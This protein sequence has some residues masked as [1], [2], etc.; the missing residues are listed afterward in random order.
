MR[1]GSL[2]VGCLLLATMAAAARPHS[3]PE[4]RA[5]WVTRTALTSPA[6][7]AQLV[8]AAASGGFNTL[9]VQVRGRGDAYFRSSFEPRAAALAAHPGFDP[10]A[11]TLRHARRAGLQ[12]HA[13]IAINLVAS[14]AA[15]PTARQHLVYRQPDWLMVPRPLAAE[16]M[17]IDPRSPEYL[18][19]LARWTS[20]NAAGVEGLYMSPLHPWAATHVTRVITE[21]AANYAVDGV[22]LDYIRFPGTDFDYSRAALQQFKVAIRPALTAA[23]RRRADAEDR[24]DPLSYPTLFPDRWL[25]FRQSRL[26]ALVARIRAT[27]TAIRP[28]AILSA[29]VVPD[30]ARAAETRFQDWRAWLDESLLDV[31]MPD[32]L[33]RRPRGVR[34]TDRR[35]A[36]AGR[37][38]VGLGRDWRL[39]PDAGDDARADPGRAAVAGRRR[40]PLFLRRARHPSQQR[41]RTARPRPGGVR[42]RSMTRTGR[43]LRTGPPRLSCMV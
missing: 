42:R 26:T 4:V 33:H 21:I 39:P 31:V 16:L 14:A 36:G 6:A 13:W 30:A 40:D 18:R 27:L 15:L 32:G 34:A 38:R 25:A 22:H 20:A 9:V 23:E 5:L 43:L 1:R 7:V 37:E 3:A 8:D 17:A 29:A 41:H 11:D 35:R 2:I 19:R 12:V 24:R 10:L 28:Q